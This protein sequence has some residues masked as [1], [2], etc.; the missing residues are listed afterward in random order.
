MPTSPST[1]RRPP[2]WAGSRASIPSAPGEL[3]C[4]LQRILARR[5]RRRPEER[6]RKAGSRVSPTV[7]LLR[8][9]PPRCVLDCLTRTLAVSTRL[10][11][12]SINQIAIA[13][14]SR[15]SA[16]GRCAGLASLICTAIAPRPLCEVSTR[17]DGLLQSYL[18]A[19]GF[20]LPCQ[21]G[22]YGSASQSPGRL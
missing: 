2:S 7:S 3:D 20:M 4:P 16:S 1:L 11:G 21:A 15:D 13:I 8:P 19:P 18:C 6:R 9:K 22:P 12:L 10:R 14:A 5:S 17:K